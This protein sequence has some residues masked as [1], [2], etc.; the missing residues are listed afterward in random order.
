M[1]VMRF[2]DFFAGIGGFHL[3]FKSAGHECVGWC[4]VNEY[5]RKSYEAMYD[6]AGL[7]TA[8][9]IRA[10]EPSDLP[11][12][13]IYC[14]G[15]PCQ[16]FSIAG[17]RGGFADTR[18]TLFFEIMRLAKARKPCV[19]VGE[20]VA[21]LL[22]HGGGRTFGTIINA[23][24]KL[25]YD[26]EWQVINSKYYVPQ[27][28]ERIYVVGHTRADGTK[29]I[30]PITG[31]IG[32]AGG[33]QGPVATTITARTG[34]ACANGTYIIED[35]Q[36]SQE[37]RLKQVPGNLYC[38][39]VEPNPAAGRVYDPSG[40]APALLDP[41]GG[42]HRETKIAIPA[43]TAQDCH[44]VA[45][46]GV[47]TGCSEEFYRGELPDCSRS[48]KA[49]KHDAAVVIRQRPHGFNKGGDHEIA[50]ALTGSS[51]QENNFIVGGTRIRKLTPREY[52]RLQGFPDDMFDRAAA[53]NSNS[54]LYKQAGNSV[55]VPVVREI[56]KG[57]AEAYGKC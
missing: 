24:G 9:D 25:G 35:R 55:T 23:M 49:S 4:E 6:V 52:F 27:N 45:V 40:I 48:I 19:L 26:V 38:T 47:Y 21:G 30:L 1:A 10:V 5:A 22:S 11:E 13:D 54:Q 39:A 34:E 17:K 51:Y 43:L 57:I 28:R 33:V 56:A 37:A 14:F 31:G 32:E 2:I 7:W 46:S 41:T 12:A 3:A 18:G 53:V 16:S 42:G 50:P 20:N 15:F 29:K 44:D 8:R 36:L